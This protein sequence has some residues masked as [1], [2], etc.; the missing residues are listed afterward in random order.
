MASTESVQGECDPRFIAVREAFA[1][2]F[3]DDLE[4]GGVVKLGDDPARNRGQAAGSSTLYRR[5]ELSQ[6]TLRRTSAG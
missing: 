4:L 6:S 2:G 3:A 1:A 5:A